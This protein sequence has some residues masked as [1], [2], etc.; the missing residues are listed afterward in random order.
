VSSTNLEPNR[1]GGL[2]SSLFGRKFARAEA[3]Q[4]LGVE[5]ARPVEVLQ[6][7]ARNAEARGDLADARADG[8][9]CTST[10]DREACSYANTEGSTDT[11]RGHL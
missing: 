6:S 5:A 11:R 1:C 7:H 8:A 10:A 3:G 2:H 4:A 9:D